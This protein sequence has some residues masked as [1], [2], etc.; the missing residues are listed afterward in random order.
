MGIKMW[1]NLWDDDANTWMSRANLTASFN[2][3]DQQLD[4]IDRRLMQ[5]DP[6]DWWNLR[7]KDPPQLK[8]LHWM[9][10]REIWPIPPLY[11]TH[12]LHLV[13]KKRWRILW[14]KKQWNFHLSAL[15]SKYVELKK[16]CLDWL[17]MYRAIWT[18]K[19]AKQLRIG[20]GKCTKCGLEEDDIHIFF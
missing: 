4:V 14:D 16:A 3:S 10:Q 15:W 2:L 12:N 8:A 1:K 13:L 6:G 17:I 20:E 5:W 18:Q 19:K 11:Q 9:N 7:I